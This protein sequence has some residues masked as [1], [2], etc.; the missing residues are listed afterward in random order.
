M[1]KSVIDRTNNSVY[2]GQN[3]CFDDYFPSR[4][5]NCNIKHVSYWIKLFTDYNNQGVKTR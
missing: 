3:G 5:K 4:M 1:K 2:Q